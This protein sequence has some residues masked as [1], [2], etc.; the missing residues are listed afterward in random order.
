MFDMLNGEFAM[1]LE[2][3]KAFLTCHGEAATEI[4]A[5][6]HW[7]CEYTT[8]SGQQLGKNNVINNY[9]VTISSNEPRCSSC[10]VGYGYKDRGFDFFISEN[11]NC[12][13]CHDST[14][15]YKKFPTGAGN[16][17]YEEIEFPGGSGKIWTPPDLSAVAQVVG[18]P[19]STNC[20]ACHFTGGG[21]PGVKHGDLDPA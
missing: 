2:V 20:G 5:K 21:A 6:T 7:L 1:G 15:T 12:L 10:H 18:V 4:M 14:G 16:P 19:S 3:T 11:V 9:C 17:T 13:I 8:D